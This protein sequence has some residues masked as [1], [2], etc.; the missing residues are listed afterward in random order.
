[1]SQIFLTSSVSEVGVRIGK[2][3]NAKE[4]GLKCLFVTTAADIER[5]D[6]TWL[7]NDRQA[8]VNGGIKVSDYT[9]IGKTR[10]MI[11]RAMETTD[12]I[13]MSGGDTFYLLMQ[14]RRTMTYDIIRK[15]VK[16]GKIYIG[17]SAGSIVA[18]PDIKYVQDVENETWVAKVKDTTG[19]RLVDLV[20]FPHWGSEDFRERYFDIKLSKAYNTDQ[21]IVLLND[22]QYVEV[23]KEGYR[24]VDVRKD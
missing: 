9:V 21:K 19:L 8:L 4:R 5:G 15:L 17:T 22:F 24:I 2:Q 23:L 7:K 6:K 13:Y 11:L 14:L 12:V 16:Q 1:M 3:L 18:G 10:K 20:I